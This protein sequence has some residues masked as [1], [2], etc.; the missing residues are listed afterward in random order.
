VGYGSVAVSEYRSFR[1]AGF[2]GG[3]GR[4]G[5]GKEKSLERRR[6]FA[7]GDSRFEAIATSHQS[8]MEACDGLKRKI[9]YVKAVTEIGSSW[10][11]YQVVIG[12][13]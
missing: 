2:C 10:N 8:V 13:Y 7:A 1:L 12:F 9:V 5:G 3:G 11:Q 6:R 4:R